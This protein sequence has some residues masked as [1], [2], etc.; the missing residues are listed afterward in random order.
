[1]FFPGFDRG[2][3]ESWLCFEV[4]L[5]PQQWS[6]VLPGLFQVSDLMPVEFLDGLV[7]SILSGASVSELLAI[8]IEEID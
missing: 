5:A 8:L 6:L 7:T 4:H 2:G 3:L 1:M